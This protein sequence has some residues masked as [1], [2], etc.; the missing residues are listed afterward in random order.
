VYS[1][2]AVTPALAVVGCHDGLVYGLSLETGADVFQVKT[3]G[4]VVS[5]PLALGD[6][7]LA[8]STD[9][10]LYLFDA[11]GQTLARLQVAA[12]GIQS[13]PAADAT[14]LVIGSARGLHA[15]RLAP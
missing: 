1:S 10:S 4:P 7:F 12:E 5:S 9:G 2:A 8:A 3:G 13:S 6:R 15:V 11:A 14:G